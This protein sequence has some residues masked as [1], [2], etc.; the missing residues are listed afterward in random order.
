MA[1]KLFISA[2][3]TIFLK[4]HVEFLALTALILIFSTRDISSPYDK[5]IASDGKGYYAYLPAIFTEHNFSYDFVE[6]YEK[7]HYLA[8][9]DFFDFRINTNTGIVN[10]YFPG[11]AILWLPFFL[12]AHLFALLFGFPPDGY[13]LPY[14]IAIAVAAVFYLWIAM[15]FLR[16]IL[17]HFGFTEPVIALV[18]WTLFLG[19]NLYY[20]TVWEPSFTH[21]Y[22]FALVN[23]FGFLVIKLSEK[24]QPSLVYLSAL[25]LGLIIITRPLNGVVLFAVPFFAGSK[26]KFIRLFQNIF[27]DKK[28]LSGALLTG[29]MVL[30]IVPLLWY[31]QNGRLLLY[32]YGNEKFDFLDP[33]LFNVLFSFRNGWL[34]YTPIALVSLAGFVPLYKNSHRRAVTLLLFLFVVLYAVSSWSVWWYGEC[35]GMRPMIE[36]Y[37][38]VAVLLSS[39]LASAK[40]KKMLFPALLILLTLL[41]ALSQFQIWQ[42][43]YGVLPAKHLTRQTYVDNFLS[44]TPKAL[45]YI[46]TTEWKPAGSY[47]TDMETDPGWL[48]YASR[49]DDNAF[50]GHFA[51]KIDSTKNQYSIGFRQNTDIQPGKQYIVV[52]SAMV[53]SSRNHTMAQLVIDFLDAGENSLEYN[54]FFLDKYLSKEKWTRIEFKAAVPGKFPGD[55]ILA[56]YF[57][58]P[59]SDETFFADDIRIDI[60]EKKYLP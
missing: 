25:L 24:Y 3:K 5:M 4:Y 37:F 29:L 27:K 34:I 36:F 16:K 10:K 11:V 19:T 51:S 26:T 13:S 31:L 1:G 32:T 23:L 18:L 42:L 45:A 30:A 56:V 2:L 14:Q 59:A 58:D 8:E 41:T 44:T 46:D 49:S 54:T 20:Y 22:S 12:G 55:G 21:V 9:D 40:R 39:L 38:I 15:K 60:L 28:T 17:R 47:F 53:Y 35:F 43:K 52:V 7:N 57:W 33:H 50:S 48:N 6:R